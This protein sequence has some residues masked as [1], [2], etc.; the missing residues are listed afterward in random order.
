MT[1]IYDIECVINAFTVIFLDVNTPKVLIEDYINADINKNIEHKKIALSNIN[2][3]EFIIFNNTN[4]LQVL[5]QFLKSANCATLVGYNNVKYDN[6]LLDYILQNS[7]L[8]NTYNID[9]ITNTLYN[10]S[11]DVVSYMKIGTYRKDFNIKYSGKYTSIDLMKLH[12]LDKKFISLKQVSISLKWYRV[13]DYTPP[14]ITTEEIFKYGY[15]G[16]IEWYDRYVLSE[17]IMGLLAYNLNDV[18]ITYMLYHEGIDELKNR[19]NTQLQYGVNV[20]SLSRSGMA[21]RLLFKGYEEATGLSYWDYKDARTYRRVI[22]FNELIIPEIKFKTKEL[23][24]FLEDLK[25]RVI[26]VGVDK[27]K[28]LIIFKGTGYTFAKGGLHSVDRPKSFVKGVNVNGYIIDWD[29]DSYYPGFV[30][31]NRIKA[32]HLLDAIIDVIEHHMLKR[33]KAKKSGDKITAGIGKILLNSGVFGKLGFEYSPMFDLKAMYQVTINLQLILLM[34]IERLELLNIH[35]ISANTDGIVAIVPEELHSLYKSTCLNL[36]AEFKFSGEFT[37]YDKYIRT[38]VND[39]LTVKNDGKVKAKG[40]FVS[41]I[42]IDKGYFA[43]AIA[44]TLY[45]YYINDNKD[46]ESIIHNYDIYDYC[47]SIKVGSQYISELH[48]IKNGSKHIEL[49]Q[50]DNRYFVSNTGGVFLKHKGEDNTYAN[51]IKGQYVT[52]FN[53]YYDSNNYNIKYS[54]YLSKVRGIINK[55]NNAI[56]KDSKG[57]KSISGN[58]FENIII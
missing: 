51:V 27:F 20:L 38:T 13:E 25:T 9:R 32:K 12:G 4:N 58:M 48:S 55:I 19:I 41:T 37:Y 29:F 34:L 31:S 35:V 45:E 8:L 56:T 21:D 43:P 30:V 33:I 54:W 57:K 1:Y 11:Q 6:L 39:Y 46:I 53:T 3:K 44:K 10:L 5:V 40:D 28:E 23:T 26:K 42:Q 2:H 47:I 18:L 24:T 36:A 22:K 49:L 15:A 7:T 50:K 17:H 52:I 14:D 16:K